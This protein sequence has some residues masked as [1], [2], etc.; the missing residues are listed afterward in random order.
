MKVAEKLKH[1]E[2]DQQIE[3]LLRDLLGRVPFVKVKSF[4]HMSDVFGSQPDWLVEVEAGD[5]PWVLAVEGKRQGQP[6]E[7]RNGLPFGKKSQKKWLAVSRV[8]S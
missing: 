7:V 1:G 5:R 6:R 2:F 4:R 3:N 8:L